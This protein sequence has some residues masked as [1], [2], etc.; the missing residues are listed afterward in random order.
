MSGKIVKNIDYS[1][2]SKRKKQA[3]NR[4]YN[5]NICSVP[6]PLKISSDSAVLV[7]GEYNCGIELTGDFGSLC[8]RV[9]AQEGTIRALQ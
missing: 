4:P 3:E 5:G 2:L 1:K 6:K 9:M 8:L 7:E